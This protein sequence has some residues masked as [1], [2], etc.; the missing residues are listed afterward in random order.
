MITS[1]SNDKVKMVRRLQTERRFRAQT[2]LFVVEGNRWIQEL[3]DQHI[4]PQHFFFTASWQATQADSLHQLQ[5]LAQHP[6]LLVSDSVMAAMSDTS[7]PPG[8]L[9]VLPTPQR[10]LPAKPS[11]LLILDGTNNP[12]NLGTMI[13]TAAAAGADGLLLAPGCVDATNPKVARGS[14]GALLRLP[15]QTATWAEIGHLTA[16]MQVW[17]AAVSGETAYTAVDWQR[18][19]ALIIGSEANGASQAA[20][21]LAQHQ[22]TI[23]MQAASE[24]LNAAVAASII[25]FEARRQRQT[26][27]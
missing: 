9:A 7:T 20:Q 15:I 16:A 24:S 18:P 22:L 10:P 8:I 1:Q 25:L 3:L 13:R 4:A 11:L 27:V 5:K 23:P 12:G 19:S 17:L 14:M 2:Q 21:Q 6:G 26:A